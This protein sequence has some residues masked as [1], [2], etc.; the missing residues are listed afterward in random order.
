VAIGALDLD[1]DADNCYFGL[2]VFY[3]RDIDEYAAMFNLDLD[4]MQGKTVLDCPAGPAA[5]A[6]QGADR[7]IKII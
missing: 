1:T 6:K 3:G 2:V 4:A 5:F 7:G